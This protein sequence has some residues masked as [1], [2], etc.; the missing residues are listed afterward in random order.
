MKGYAFI[1]CF[2]LVLLMTAVPVT[3]TT[4]TISGDS[5]SSVSPSTGQKGDTVY[6]CNY[7][8]ELYDNDRI[9]KAREKR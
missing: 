8:F 2:I 9:R 3:A 4:T 5:I 1:V 6:R 7:R